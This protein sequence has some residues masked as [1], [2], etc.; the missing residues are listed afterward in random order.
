M[1]EFSEML[2]Q[3][4]TSFDS[5]CDI[6]QDAALGNGGLGRLA[7]CYMDGMASQG[8]PATGFSILYEYGF[9]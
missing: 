3:M 8:L 9:F 6:E 4:G 1:H 5:I 2:T 7:A